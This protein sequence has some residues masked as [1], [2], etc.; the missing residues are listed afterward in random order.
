MNPAF[1]GGLI[2]DPDWFRARYE[3]DGLSFKEIAKLADRSLR[4]A[5]RWAHKH[6]IKIR[7]H[8]HKR[9]PHT[10]PNHHNWKGGG[11]KCRDCGVPVSHQGVGKT[12]RCMSC[13]NKAF[14]GKGNPNYK[15]VA[16]INAILR[17]Y[18][19][20][21]WRL[22]VFAKDRYT[23]QRCGDAK[24]GNLTAHHITR[25]AVLVERL[26]RD[27]SLETAEERLEAVAILKTASEMNDLANGITLCED[28]HKAVH[29]VYAGEVIPVDE[30]VSS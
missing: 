29:A 15:G 23:C 4:T 22:K 25:F 13:R 26:L 7:P 18:L 24:G 27:R 16:D 10:G 30:R 9:N 21:T 1:K 5:A 8:G 12:P 3:D 2:T 6:G 14:T 20:N 19:K 17:E 11:K 28:C